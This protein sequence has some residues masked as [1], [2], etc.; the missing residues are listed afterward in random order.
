MRAE[1][2]AKTGVGGEAKRVAA[3]ARKEGG[4]VLDTARKLPDKDSNLEP[5]G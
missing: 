2:S 3:L 1:V 4:I 5:S